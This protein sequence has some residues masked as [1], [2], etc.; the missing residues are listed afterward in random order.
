MIM[1]DIE[2]IAAAFLKQ[3]RDKRD[4]TIK[5]ID[6]SM[7]SVL[8]LKSGDKD[9]TFNDIADYFIHDFESTVLTISK[10]LELTSMYELLQYQNTLIM[11]ITYSKDLIRFL[12][13]NTGSINEYKIARE[14]L[15]K[16]ITK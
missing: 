15:S 5:C 3:L 1:V 14:V 11:E 10:T 16:W 8:D 12:S 13:E 2:T 4:D 7:Q 9:I 6:S